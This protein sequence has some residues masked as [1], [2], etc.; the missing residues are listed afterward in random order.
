MS[1]LMNF[2]TGA[3]T[4]RMIITMTLIVK[5]TKTIVTMIVMMTM[6]IVTK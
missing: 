2:E 5:M 6:M 4:L 1:V 3:M